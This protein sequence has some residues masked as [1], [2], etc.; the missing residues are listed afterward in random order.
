VPGGGEK[1]EGWNGTAKANEASPLWIRSGAESLPGWEA[2]RCS[3][4]ARPIP[5]LL[6]RPGSRAKKGTEGHGG[7]KLRDHAPTLRRGLPK[8][9]LLVKEIRKALSI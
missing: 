8:F 4:W 2:K 3:G 7:R 9:T 1:G 5:L 6:T